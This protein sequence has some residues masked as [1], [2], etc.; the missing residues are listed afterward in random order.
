MY[1]YERY[2]RRKKLVKVRVGGVLWKRR[3]S[4]DGV[5]KRVGW[6]DGWVVLLEEL[7]EGCVKM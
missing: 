4:F 1:E 6:V 2:K 5:E 3:M 7:W